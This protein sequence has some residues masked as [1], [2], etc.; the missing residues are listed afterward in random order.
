MNISLRNEDMNVNESSAVGS[1]A[2]T[3]SSSRIS[4][5]SVVRFYGQLVYHPVDVTGMMLSNLQDLFF[6][7]LV[8][9]YT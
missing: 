3:H 8:F 1:R 4:A 7:H 9:A 5:G 6:F 2:A